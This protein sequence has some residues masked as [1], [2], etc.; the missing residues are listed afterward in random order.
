MFGRRIR[1]LFDLL[2]PDLFTKASKKQEEQTKSF[3]GRAKD[4]QFYQGDY[5]YVRNF[6]HRNSVPWITSVIVK[7]IGNVSYM[8]RNTDN[9]VKR[10]V[11]HI[12]KQIVDIIHESNQCSP[13]TSNVTVTIPED[14]GNVGERRYPIRLHRPPQHFRDEFYN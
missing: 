9:V 14:L 10:H 5:V 12:C 2:Q 13:D 4:R 1:T 7:R 6:S 3:N 11:N 8:E